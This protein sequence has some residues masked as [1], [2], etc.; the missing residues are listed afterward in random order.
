[1]GEVG[2]LMSNHHHL[3]N[4]GTGDSDAPDSAD[5]PLRHNWL[6]YVAGFFL[7][8]ALIGFILEG[9]VA[10]RPSPAVT[11]PITANGSQK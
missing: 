8:I 5:R 11:P 9:T 7:M 4:E 10:W 1:M 6:F 3:P 2:V